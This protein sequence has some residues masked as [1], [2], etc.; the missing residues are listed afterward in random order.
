ME[1]IYIE[2]ECRIEKETQNTAEAKKKKKEKSMDSINERRSVDGRDV[3]V[4]ELERGRLDQHGLTGCEVVSR[5][6]KR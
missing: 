3:G 5:S 4:V 2:Y 6:V 1:T